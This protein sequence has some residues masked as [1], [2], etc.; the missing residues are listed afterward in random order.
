MARTAVISNGHLAVGLNEQGLVHDFY[1]PY[2]GQDNLTTARSTHHKIGIWVDGQFS[3]V[4]EHDWSVSVDYSSEAQEARVVFENQHLQLRIETTDFVDQKY[5]AF[6]R[7]LILINH[8]DHE[9]EVRLFMHQVFELSRNGRADT[10]LYVPEDNYIMNYK[11]RTVLIAAGNVPGALH[12]FD[13]YAVGNYGI[14]GKEG[15]FRDAEDGELSGHSVEHAGVDS[16]M[17]FQLRI[18]A[19]DRQPVDYWVAA[20][21][22]PYNTEQVHNIMKLGL[23]KRLVENRSIWSEWLKISDDRI[24]TVPEQY[25]PMIRKSLLVI[26][27]HLDER[28]GVIASCD[29]S[30]YNYGRD[31]YSYVWPRDG[32]YAVWPLIRL[33]YTDEPK[34]F[35]RFCRDVIT[36]GGYLMHKYQPDRATGSTWHSLLQNG[37]KE[38][39]IQEDETA[40][41]LVA[42]G[43]FFTMTRDAEFLKEMYSDFILPAATFLHDFIDTQ[44]GLPHASFDLWE[45]KFATHTYTTAIVYRALKVSSELAKTFGTAQQVEAWDNRAEELLGNRHVFTNY[46]DGT[47]RK[48]YL[49]QDDD[50]LQFDNTLD[51]SSLYGV[52]TYGYFSQTDDQTIHKDVQACID[53]LSKNSPT[54]GV[55]RYLHDNYFKSSD[56]YTG[57]PWLIST[58][59]LAQAHVFYRQYEEAQSLLD[60]VQSCALPSGMLSEQVDPENST[61]VSVTPL[62][63][64]HAEFINTVLYLTFAKQ[65]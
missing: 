57:N 13:Q 35:F 38:L 27:A 12:G 5:D 45:E 48:S 15:T 34:A 53:L 4:G 37:K 33:G 26:K 65:K 58:L 17:R 62:V 18:K 47:F 24:N 22:S 32:A 29:S 31:Y 23:D 55:P 50:S 25:R 21:D 52:I 3:W 36:P 11:G 40:A 46:G 54:P 42:L 49:L 1:Y 10:A 64:S 61:P 56:V 6:C 16:V 19:G 7:K 14:E 8:A 28:G 60:W 2:V 59:W 43:E 9:R 44:T 41:V 39:A 20:G 30:I 63:W 51:M